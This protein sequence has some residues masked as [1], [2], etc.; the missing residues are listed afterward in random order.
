MFCHE[1]FFR[2]HLPLS[3]EVYNRLIIDSLGFMVVDTIKKHLLG[4]TQ[5]NTIL[6]LAVSS[7]LTFWVRRE[8]PRWIVLT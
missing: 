6:T 8:S 4:F 7:Y 2:I 3:Y 5:F 1:V